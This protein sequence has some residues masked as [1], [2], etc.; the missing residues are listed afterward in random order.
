MA[1][2]TNGFD[3]WMGE[4]MRPF[5]K[6][7]FEIVRNLFVVALLSYVANKSDYSILKLFAFFTYVL[8]GLYCMS[9]VVESMPVTNSKAPNVVVRWGVNLV[10]TAFFVTTF[11][12]WSNVIIKVLDEVMKLQQ[13]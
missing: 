3:R 10:G 12:I 7:W 9:F 11:Y 4:K 1:D 8:F 6:I 13:R 2:Y 5:A